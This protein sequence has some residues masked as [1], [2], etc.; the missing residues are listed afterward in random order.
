MSQAFCVI[1]LFMLPAGI[2]YL[3]TDKGNYN[4]LKPYLQLSLANM[5]ISRPV[6]IQQYVELNLNR[7]IGCGN[8]G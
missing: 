8:S 5:N 4:E 3:E 1:S 6:C 2:F 7:S